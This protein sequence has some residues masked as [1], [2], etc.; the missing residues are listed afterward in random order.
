MFVSPSCHT[1]FGL[2]QRRVLGWSINFQAVWNLAN[3]LR[4]RLIIPTFTAG[5][6]WWVSRIAAVRGIQPGVLLLGLF[7]WLHSLNQDQL[8]SDAMCHSA[9]SATGKWSFS[10]SFVP[11]LC[12]WCICD[13]ISAVLQL[14]R[15]TFFG[16]SP[17]P[18]RL[19]YLWCPCFTVPL[20]FRVQE[21]V[22]IHMSTHQETGTPAL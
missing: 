4:A 9:A 1:S 18:V 19:T 20:P 2:T 22:Q 12:F 8:W 17:M 15:Q 10:I 5:S 3:Q 13:V 6:N 14:C 11:L 7:F 16:F 21:C